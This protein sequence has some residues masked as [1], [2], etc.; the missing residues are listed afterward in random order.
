MENT[1]VTDERI[2]Q[3]LALIEDA[4]AVVVGTASGM[5]AAG[6]DSYYD[7]NPTFLAYFGDIYEKFGSRAG[8]IFPAFYYPYPHEEQRQ[9]AIARVMQM[10][11]ESSVPQQYWDLKELLQGKEFFMVTTNQDQLARRTFGDEKTAF[12]QGD[13]GWLQ[14]GKPCH[15]A[16]YSNEEFVNAAIADHHDCALPEE[17]VP[18][19]PKCGAVMEPWVRGFTFLEG[20]LYRDQYRKYQAFLEKHL[21]D[22]VLFLE[23]GVGAMTPMFIKEPFWNYT[24]QWPGGAQYAPITLGHAVVPDA[25]ADKSLP[26]DAEIDKVLHRA[27]ELKRGEAFATQSDEFKREEPIACPTIEGTPARRN[28]NGPQQGA[29]S[30]APRERELAGARR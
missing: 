30:S 20:S 22:R 5:S 1:P 16:V 26:F 29:R 24:H 19:C 11:R 15:D 21:N 12:I 17:L 13:W 23:L 6:G 18:R 10:V 4:D 9:Y 7:V 3:L 14:C 8:G 28:G 27:A 2:Q 25:I